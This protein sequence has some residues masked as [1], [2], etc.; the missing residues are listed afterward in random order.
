MKLTAIRSDRIYRD[1]MTALPGEK[2]AIY[3]NQLMKPFEYKWACVGIPGYILGSIAPNAR[4][5]GLLP[6]GLRIIGSASIRLAL[7]AAY[8]YIL[9][10]LFFSTTHTGDIA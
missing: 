3:R 5:L 7:I 10:L 8:R 1:M 9:R 4:S 6:V 2:E